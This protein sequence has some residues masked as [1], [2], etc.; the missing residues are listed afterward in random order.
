MSEKF[1]KF[2]LYGVPI[3]K[4]HDIQSMNGSA[5][6]KQ[7]KKQK[8][9]HFAILYRSH[10]K[11]SFGKKISWKTYK[12]SGTYD[13]KQ[14]IW[15]D[16]KEKFGKECLD[17]KVPISFQKKMKAWYE[18][19]SAKKNTDTVLSLPCYDAPYWS[20]SLSSEIY[21]TGIQ[22]Q[23]AWKANNKDLIEANGYKSF[24]LLGR[25]LYTSSGV[26]QWTFPYTGN[27]SF[28]SLTRGVQ[29]RFVSAFS[30]F[31][32][33][34]FGYAVA[35]HQQMK[36]EDVGFTK[37]FFNEN[38]KS[39][40]LKIIQPLSCTHPIHVS[41]DISFCN[42]EDQEEVNWLLDFLKPNDLGKQSLR[43]NIFLNNEPLNWE[44]GISVAIALRNLIVHGMLSPSK[45]IQNNF[46]YILP[47]LTT[48]LVVSTQLLVEDVLKNSQAS[49]PYS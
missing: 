17:T 43:E 5:F 37:L 26:V 20:S 46:I 4:Q 14:K 22:L 39:I 9:F 47:S 45:T 44:T 15:K 25:S 23:K 8:Y 42:K 35:N 24:T 30:G 10:S 19:K 3:S 36:N 13:K 28:I 40:F 2:V 31:E 21:W 48:L 12:F 16:V 38:F 7:E 11:D 6:L 1:E 27:M 34:C 49:I 33:A 18:R 41:I 29:L 32:T